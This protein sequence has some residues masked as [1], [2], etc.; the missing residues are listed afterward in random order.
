MAPDLE[1]M[2]PP[3]LELTLGALWRAIIAGEKLS[4]L[5]GSVQAT[6]NHFKKLLKFRKRTTV[7]PSNTQKILASLVKSDL[8]SL[9]VMILL[10]LEPVTVVPGPGH[11]PSHQ[12][13]C[14]I[15]GLFNR[16]YMEYY[17]H[18]LE[19]NFRRCTPDLIKVREQLITLECFE[20][21]NKSNGSQ[22]RR[23]HYHECKET[24]DRIIK[25]VEQVKNID[26][27]TESWRWCQFPRCSNPYGIYEKG[28]SY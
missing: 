26:A 17:G 21:N 7:N 11:Y 18:L 16:I 2:L 23:K 13:I 27:S 8:V 12:V 28:A 15:E 9:T 1:E 22:Q 6:F 5:L 20:S 25:A 24:W 10:R 19:E 4:L 14:L 3:V